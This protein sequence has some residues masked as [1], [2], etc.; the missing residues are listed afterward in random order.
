MRGVLMRFGKNLLMKIKSIKIPITNKS[1]IAGWGFCGLTRFLPEIPPD[2]IKVT[3]MCH[4]GYAI[5]IE[6]YF[7]E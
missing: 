3:V 5:S 7:N 1:Y 6:Q 4:F 2:H